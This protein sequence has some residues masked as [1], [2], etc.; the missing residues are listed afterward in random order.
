[1]TP[2]ARARKIESYGNAFTQLSDAVVAFPAK[3]WTYSPGADRWSIQEIVFHLADSEAH[4]FIRCRTAI[5]EPGKP[6]MVYDQ[7]KWTQHLNYDNRSVKDALELFR[8]LRKSSYEL[9]KSLPD[10][11][12]TQTMNHSERGLLTLDDWLDMYE[13]HVTGHI[14]QMNRVY[15]DWK[16]SGE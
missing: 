4:G 12:W 7:I 2:E 3:M 1:M 13:G 5:A 9:I 16:K 15:E 14:T 10:S 6:V 8:L 11:A